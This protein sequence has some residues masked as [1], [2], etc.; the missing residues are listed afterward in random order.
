V[1]ELEELIR[2]KNEQIEIVK[3]QQK[4]EKKVAEAESKKLKSAMEILVKSDQRLNSL[5]NTNIAKL[6]Q[7]I[8][9]KCDRI[10]VQREFD[11]VAT[12]VKQV[13]EQI[14]P[15]KV[16]PKGASEE[17]FQKQLHDVQIQKQKL[18]IELQEERQDFKEYKIEY[19]NYKQ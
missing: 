8:L 14:T 7:E 12:T 18:E 17:S 11:V 10:I 4:E 3:K 16:D 13:Q 15:S 2:S 9:G 5:I 19:Q 1:E 6:K